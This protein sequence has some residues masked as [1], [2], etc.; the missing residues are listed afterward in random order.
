VDDHYNII[1]AGTTA[2]N[3]EFFRIAGAALGNEIANIFPTPR[4]A[5]QE[6]GNWFS[7]NR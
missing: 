2:L 5:L 1:S 6:D 3:R 4:A 7:L